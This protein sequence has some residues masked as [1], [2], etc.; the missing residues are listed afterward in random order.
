MHKI[1]VSLCVALATTQGLSS[2]R[3]D[4]A[5]LEVLVR[6]GTPAPNTEAG[7]VFASFGA[8]VTNDLGTYAFAATLTSASANKTGIW[9]GV[10]GNW[11][12]LVR[13]GQAMPSNL[14]ALQRLDRS[15]IVLNN[16]DAVAFAARSGTGAG[17]LSIFRATRAGT[18]TVIASVGMQAPGLANGVTFRDL[19]EPVM[20]ASGQIAFNAS[21]QGPGITDANQGSAWLYSGGVLRTVM[22]GGDMMIISQPSTT[23]RDLLSPILN[24]NSKAAFGGVVQGPLVNPWN[25]SARWIATNW[26]P[27]IQSFGGTLVGTPGEGGDQITLQIRRVLPGMHRMNGAGT[28]A[29][30]ADHEDWNSPSKF[31]HGIWTTTPTGIK[32]VA[33]RTTPVTALG[34][35][36]SLASYSSLIIDANNHIHFKASLAGQFVTSQNDNAFFSA[37]S[38]GTL[39]QRLRANDGAPG[40]LG[41][42]RLRE[43]SPYAAC[44]PNGEL[45]LVA[46]MSGPTPNNAF[47]RVLMT[48]YPSGEISKVV[49]SGDR[50]TVAPGITK[51]VSGIPNF[52]AG[53]NQDGQPSAINA[54]GSFVFRLE[55]TDSS[56]ALCRNVLRP[57]CPGDFDGNR[58]V[59]DYDFIVFSEYF[60]ELAGGPGDLDRDGLTSDSDFVRFAQAYATLVCP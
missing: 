41:Q 33:T 54:S 37:T 40:M 31:A 38:N 30:F 32:P 4:T 15:A 29:F 49:A 23:V 26:T 47:E 11:R 42:R 57:A 22:K 60:S 8:P 13:E 2:A 56:S 24:N 45:F 25:D 27:T 58:I 1:V 6:S 21:L 39:V 50:V 5:P 16:A 35:A 12:L 53:N 3:A 10:P 20:N 9:I 14:G 44:G 51:T 34:E 55:F 59:D 28:I 17:K 18:V 7:T 19:G 43:L 52:W 36:V 46:P 48:S